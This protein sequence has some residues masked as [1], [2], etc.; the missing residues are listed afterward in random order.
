VVIPV[1]LATLAFFAAGEVF[2]VGRE[3]SVFRKDAFH[4]AVAL[5]RRV[6]EKKIVGLQR[7]CR[8]SE[9]IVD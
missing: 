9:A 8:C 4:G 1:I 5:S 6:S 7:K 2:R 3:I